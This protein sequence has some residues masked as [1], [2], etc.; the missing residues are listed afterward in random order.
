MAFTKLCAI[1][2]MRWYIIEDNVSVF[3]YSFGHFHVTVKREDRSDGCLAASKMLLKFPGI[4]FQHLQ[5][6]YV[7]L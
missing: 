5:C 6:G 3:F 1:K 4:L 7:I 2:Q